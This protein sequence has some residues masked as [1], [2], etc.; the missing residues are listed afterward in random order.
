MKRKLVTLVVFFLYVTAVYSQDS[1]IYLME[2]KADKTTT[3]LDIFLGPSLEV[4]KVTRKEFDNKATYDDSAYEVKKEGLTYT[5]YVKNTGTIVNSKERGV[6]R[7]AFTLI[8]ESSGVLISLID[9]KG[10]IHEY[11]VTDKK[12]ADEKH[13]RSI[14][15]DAMVFDIVN[16]NQKY[17][18]TRRI[19]GSYFALG[20]L[21]FDPPYD[22]VF[23]VQQIESDTFVANSNDDTG[24]T[25]TTYRTKQISGQPLQVFA[26]NYI[27]LSQ[28]LDDTDLVPYLVVSKVN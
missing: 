26:T 18:M 5:V 27:I 6:R 12:I 8:E 3:S 14:S 19:N 16:G 7:V 10:I 25:T 21:V 9:N 1:A 15:W 24:T 28:I 22:G 13:M 20:E 23:K 17:H 4:Q 2:R 11:R